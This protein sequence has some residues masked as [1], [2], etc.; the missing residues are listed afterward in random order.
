MLRTNV[1][2]VSTKN[3][4]KKTSLAV[5]FGDWRLLRV[6]AHRS[7]FINTHIIYAS[8]YF[9]I[10]LTFLFIGHHFVRPSH[11][12]YYNGSV[13]ASTAFNVDR[14]IWDYECTSH[15]ASD[16]NRRMDRCR[17]CWY[18][19]PGMVAQTRCATRMHGEMKNCH[20][21]ICELRKRLW[22]ENIALVELV[23]CVFVC[24]RARCCTW[25]HFLFIFIRVSSHCFYFH[26]WFAM[27]IKKVKKIKQ[28]SW[29]HFECNLSA[30]RCRAA[31]PAEKLIVYALA[32]GTKEFRSFLLLPPRCVDVFCIQIRN[33]SSAFHLIPYTKIVFS[34]SL[35]G[36]GFWFYIS[37][38]IAS[39]RTTHAHT[40]RATVHCFGRMPFLLSV[41]LHVECVNCEKW[42][43]MW[44]QM[45]I[46]VQNPINERQTY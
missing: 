24:A 32:T 33:Y 16:K 20:G 5:D 45:G 25:T 12:V 44:S 41:L 8:H 29:M 31:A 30:S 18:P 46:N 43:G 40:G 27:E 3:R 28:Q 39:M 15:S 11:I 6:S 7:I 36:S 35:A 13:V 2:A 26:I 22:N 38:S 42:N 21:F 37:S 4:E 1:P 34:L 17:C 14:S 10:Y 23:G 9:I 19:V